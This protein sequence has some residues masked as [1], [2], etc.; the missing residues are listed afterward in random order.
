MA[1]FL[2]VHES[3]HDRA[4]SPYEVLAGIAIEDRTVRTVIGRLHK[5]EIRW[6]GRRYS[7]GRRELKGKRLL[8]RK[9]YRR[10]EL[11]AEVDVSDIAALA[12]AALDDG[13]RTDPRMLTA[14]AIAKLNYVAS[15]FDIC[16]Q[17]GCRAFASIVDR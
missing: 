8:K 3:G 14:L 16:A 5:A 13:V 10:R 2:F 12:R 6:F 7:Y 1:W 4:A 17:L 9:V 15:V 11:N